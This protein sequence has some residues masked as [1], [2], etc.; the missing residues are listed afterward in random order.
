V[1]V[2]G[3]VREKPKKQDW[4]WQSDETAHFERKG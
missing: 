3:Q 2:G 4:G 1:P